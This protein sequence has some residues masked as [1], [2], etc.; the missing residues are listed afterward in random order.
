MGDRDHAALELLQEALEPGHRLGVEVVRG[1]VEEQHVGRLQQQAAQRDPALLAA[2]EGRH[3]RVPRR[4]A[5][6]VHR[7][8]DLLVEVPEV[9][10]VDLVLQ[11][12]ELVGGVVRV[13]GRDLLVALQDLPLLR[14]RLLD[15]LEHV[16]RGV[17]LGL[18][19]QVADAGALGRERLAREVLVHPGHDPEEG[20]LAGPVRAE[21]A[22]LGVPVERQ[23][24]ALEDLLPLGRDLAQ[25]LHGEDELGHAGRWLSLPS[26]RGRLHREGPPGAGGP[27]ILPRAPVTGGSARSQRRTLFLRAGRRSRRRPSGPRAPRS[28]VRVPAPRDGG[29]PRRPRG[30]P[31]GRAHEGGD[32]R[33]ERPHRQRARAV[34]DRGRPRGRAPRPPG[35]EGEGRGPLGPGGGRGRRGGPRGRGRGRAPRRREHRR[36]ALDRG[37]EGAPAL[38]P[39]GADAAPRPDARGPEEEAE[40]A[41]L[42]LRDRLLREPGR[43]VGDRER[44]ARRRLPRPPVGRV[45]GRGR[46]GPAGR[47]PRR[48]P[49]LRHRPE[50]RGR[51]PREDAAALQGWAWA[52]WWARARST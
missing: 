13:V 7:E 47:H 51:R 23:P 41:R 52:G 11:A 15:V 31:R 28:D 20:R 18:L 42:G 1:L 17:E 22:D 3:V 45:G 4:Q 25:V 38:E 44:P 36:G 40:G 33:R 6:R 10:R 46:A 35:P 32:H 30:V 16:L 14:H 39:R 19:G 26:P 27:S 2:R 50:P 24:D 9:L 37:P 43:R 12:R 34:P 29:R 8:L 21:D 49:A 5:Q 48:P